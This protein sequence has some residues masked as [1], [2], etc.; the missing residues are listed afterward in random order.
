MGLHPGPSYMGLL[1]ISAMI[2]DIF[3]N[4]RS[5]LVVLGGGILLLLLARQLP[6]DTSFQQVRQAGTLRVCHPPQLEPFFLRESEGTGGKEAELAVRIGQTLGLAVQFEP[7]SGWGLG[8]DPVDWGL[9]PE[10]CDLVLGGIIYSLNTRRLLTLL[11]YQQ[12]EWVLLGKDNTKVGLWLPFWGAP[13]GTLISWLGPQANLVYPES[14]EEAHQWLKHGVVSSLLT[15]KEVADWLDLE[16]RWRRQTLA[17][18]QLAIGLWKGRT[19]LK[20]AVE[21]ALAKASSKS[22]P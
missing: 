11:P 19:T 9:R 18:T 10:S 6:P 7:Q 22:K 14:L 20:R 12:S 1:R 8:V 5:S 16:G 15:L 2:R 3:S 21:K 17:S 4:Y 13:V